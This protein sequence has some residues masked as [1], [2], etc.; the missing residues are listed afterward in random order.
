MAT[1]DPAR[2][3]ALACLREARVAVLAVKLSADWRPVLVMA[4][5]KSSRDNVKPYRVRFSAGQWT[6]TCDARIADGPCPHIRAVSLVTTE[7]AA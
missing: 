3:K 7:A 1:T 5:V 4:R 6:C 2:S